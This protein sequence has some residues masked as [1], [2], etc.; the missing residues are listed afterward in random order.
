MREKIILTP[1]CNGTELQRA[2]ARFGVN[3]IGYR[4]VSDVELAKIALMRSGISITEDF[5]S[6]RE[7]PSVIFSFLNKIE[8]FSSASYADAE[9]LSVAL[10]TMRGL[11]TDNEEEQIKGALSAGEFKDKN[12]AI[13]EV[14]KQYRKR[15]NRANPASPSSLCE[16]EY[17]ICSCLNIHR[18][19][20]IKTRIH[21]THGL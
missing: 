15:V 12:D 3:T 14:Y 9:A 8:Y 10:H 18:T 4:I 5:L 16:T 2:L 7:E 6:S 21:C 11:V 19:E 13:Y 20:E 17:P 1:G